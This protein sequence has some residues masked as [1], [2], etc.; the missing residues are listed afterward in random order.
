MN[1]L[2]F[3]NV[4]LKKSKTIDKSKPKLTI[5]NEV[6]KYKENATSTYFEKW[7]GELKEYTFE[8]KVRRN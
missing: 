1:Q 5:S 4:K 6:Q 2:N 8:S 3:K 7:Y